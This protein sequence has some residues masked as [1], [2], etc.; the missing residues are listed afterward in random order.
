MVF[1]KLFLIWNAKKI[2]ISSWTVIFI[3]SELLFIVNCELWKHQFIACEMS[4]RTSFTTLFS[5]HSFV[6][7][8]DP[9]LLG[10]KSLWLQA[11]C[12]IW[13]LKP[14]MTLGHFAPGGGGGGTLGLFGWGC[15]AGTMEPLAYTRASSR[16]AVFQ[17]QL[18]SLAQSNQNKTP[19]WFFLYSWVTIPSFP[20]LD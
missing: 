3:E 17:K 18:R 16:V 4:S 20:S 6:G 1:A 11:T 13:W 10:T 5:F 8:S 19:I 9:L 12:L 14:C 2:L 15:A 7:R